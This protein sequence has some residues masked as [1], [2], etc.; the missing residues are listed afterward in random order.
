MRPPDGLVVP[1]QKRFFFQYVQQ[2]IIVLITK[3]RAHIYPFDHQKQITE[4]DLYNQLLMVAGDVEM[5]SWFALTPRAIMFPIHVT[6]LPP[7]I[8]VNLDLCQRVI[9]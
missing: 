8:C 2:I 5:T 7:D 6:N 4:T 1:P 9:G 3:G